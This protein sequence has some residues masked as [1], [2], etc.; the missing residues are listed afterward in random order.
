MFRL[1]ILVGSLQLQLAGE[2]SEE[3][4]CHNVEQILNTF[5]FNPMPTFESFLVASSCIIFEKSNF[6]NV[7]RLPRLRLYNCSKYILHFT[8]FLFQ[9]IELYS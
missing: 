3:V 9:S 7:N 4:P 6:E 5:H 8:D 1:V 2:L